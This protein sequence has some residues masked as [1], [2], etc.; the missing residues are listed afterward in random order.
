MESKLLEANHYHFIGIGGIGMSAIAIALIE[1]GFSVSGSD[2]IKNKQ[3][4]KIEQ[5]GIDLIYSQE[6]KNIDKVQAKYPNKNLIIVISSA[7]KEKNREFTYCR[8]KKLQ[9]KHRSEILS[10]IMQTYNSIGVAGSHGKTSTSTFLSTLL[11]LCTKDSSSIVGGIQ[12]IYN[13]NTNIK[14]TKYIVAE[15]DESDGSTINYNT[16]LGIITNI[17]FDHCDHYKNL[18]EV[19]LSFKKFALNSKKLLINNDCKTT[20]NNIF[21]SHNWSIKQTKNID[22]SLIPKILNETNTI[23]DYYE[24]EKFIDTLDIPIAGLHNISNLIAAIAACRLQK[25]NYLKIKKNIKYLSLPKRRFELKGEFKHRKIIDDYAHHPTEIKASIELGKLYIKGKKNSCERLVV[26]FQPH[27]YSR[28]AKFL[29]DFVEVLI[30]ADSIIITDIYSS[31]EENLNNISSELIKNK[32]YKFNKNVTYLK[33]NYEIKTFFE[34]ITNKNDLVLNMG[35][36]DCN[37]LWPILNDTSI[38]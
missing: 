9:I 12:P 18:E 28:V 5:M 24:K 36:G 8:K 11:D 23:A 38:T 31:G 34:K 22:Y 27:R 1:K 17:D 3:T 21:Y 13:S 19:I 29:D 15:I 20:K 33:D 6:E 4:K 35:A 37:N 30:K 2:L 10:L 25:V 14:E 32:I 16:D 7:I 26:I